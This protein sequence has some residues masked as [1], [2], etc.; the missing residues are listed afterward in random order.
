MRSYKFN[1]LLADQIQAFHL[2]PS[3]ERLSACVINPNT[4]A[5]CLPALTPLSSPLPPLLSSFLL[6]LF[7]TAVMKFNRC[8]FPVLS[9][10]LILSS[11]SPS[12]SVS[13][14][15]T[16]AEVRQAHSVPPSTQSSLLSLPPSLTRSQRCFLLNEAG[17]LFPKINRLS[18]TNIPN[19]LLQGLHTPTHTHTLL[20]QHWDSNPKYLS[21]V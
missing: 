4:T 10:V 18:Q 21:S 11:F 14:Q 1:V 9:H 2:L 7:P 12:L 19:H 16:V 13:L 5:A 6:P 20:C 17:D 15:L 3:P 8:S